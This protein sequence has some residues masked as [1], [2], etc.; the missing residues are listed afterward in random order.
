[1]TIPFCTSPS[2]LADRLVQNGI[3]II[4]LILPKMTNSTKWYRH[5]LINPAKDDEQVQNGI[6]I[7][8]LILPKMTD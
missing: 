8:S 1:M 4:S 3:V 5:H 2:S 6:V 7:I